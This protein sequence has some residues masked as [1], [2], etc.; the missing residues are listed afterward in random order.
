MLEEYIEN[1]VFEQYSGNMGMNHHENHLVEDYAR[2][3][4]SEVNYREILESI[5][6]NENLTGSDIHKKI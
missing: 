1:A 6:D 2:A 5:L 3:F 4:L